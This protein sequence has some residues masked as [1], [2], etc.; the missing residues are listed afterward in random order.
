MILRPHIRRVEEDAILAKEDK[1][2][3]RAAA[4]ALATAWSAPAAAVAP[5]TGW[6]AP[7]PAEPAAEVGGVM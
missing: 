3:D 5:T 7:A 4:V 1:P 2:F 6:A